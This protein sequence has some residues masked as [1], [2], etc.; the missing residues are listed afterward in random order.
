M[1]E[2]RDNTTWAQFAL[3]NLATWAAAIGIERML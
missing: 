2:T 1:T 3:M